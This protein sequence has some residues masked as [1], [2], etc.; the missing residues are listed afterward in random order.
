MGCKQHVHLQAKGCKGLV[1]AAK[2]CKGMQRG[3]KQFKDVQVKGCKQH[4][5]ERGAKFSGSKSSMLF[6]TTLKTIFAPRPYSSSPLEGIRPQDDTLAFHRCQY[7]PAHDYCKCCQCHHH[8]RHHPCRQCHQ[9]GQKIR[10]TTM[11]LTAQAMAMAII[12][13]SMRKVTT[14]EAVLN[15]WDLVVDNTFKLKS[16][17]FYSDD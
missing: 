15:P 9:K 17:W 12:S 13:P 2:G 7:S 6:A 3:P 5:Q 10:D 16:S 4:V 11:T 8:Q 1:R 14:P